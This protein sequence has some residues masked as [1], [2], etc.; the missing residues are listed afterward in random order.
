[1]FV[2][3]SFKEREK[4]RTDIKQLTVSR[5]LTNF[6]PFNNF[7]IWNLSNVLCSHYT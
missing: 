5:K 3:F 6:T 1:M 7:K 2:C 4:I